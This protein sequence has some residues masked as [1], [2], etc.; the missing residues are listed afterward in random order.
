MPIAHAGHRRHLQFYQRRALAQ[1]QHRTLLRRHLLSSSPSAA[2]SLLPACGSYYTT[3][4]HDSCYSLKSVFLLTEGQLLALNPDIDCPRPGEGVAV[5]VA[6]A[7]ASPR[8]QAAAGQGAAGGVGDRPGET[9]A[10]GLQSDWR[11]M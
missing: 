4:R 9:W 8:S 10:L 3:T 11:V 5:C 7:P 6:E 1:Q 2:E